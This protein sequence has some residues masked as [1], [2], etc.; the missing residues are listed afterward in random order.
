[1]MGKK[2]EQE[3]GSAL[4]FLLKL[5]GCAD[6]RGAYPNEGDPDAVA[7]PFGFDSAALRSG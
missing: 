7:S 1:M 3:Q 5:F 4:S 2:K 6:R